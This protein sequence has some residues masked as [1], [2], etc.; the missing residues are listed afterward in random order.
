[1]SISPTATDLILRGGA[2]IYPAEVEAALDAHPDVGSSVA[3]GLPDADLGQRVHAIV[4]PKPDAAG[5]LNAT[6]LQC[7]LADRIARYKVPESYEFTNDCLRDDA[8]KVRRSAL[9]EKRVT[10]L[11]EGRAFRVETAT[12]RNPGKPDHR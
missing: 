12:S 7:F 2:N 3:I 1:M 9:R 6:D 11:R 5:R 10:W 8:G 4:Q